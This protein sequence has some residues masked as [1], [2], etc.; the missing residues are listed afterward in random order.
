MYTCSL[1]GFTILKDNSKRDRY[2]PVY[3]RLNTPYTVD[4]MHSQGLDKI[5]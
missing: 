3:R 1:E 5:A 2:G 4:N